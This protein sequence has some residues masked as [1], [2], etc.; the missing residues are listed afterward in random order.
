MTER[1]QPTAVITGATSERGIG[2]TVADRYAGHGVAVVVLDLDG[3]RAAEVAAEIAERPRRA[4]L[5]RGRE[6][7]RRGGGRRSAGRR[8]GRGRSGPPAHGR[9]AREHRQHHLARAV[10]RGRPGPSRIRSWP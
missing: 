2:M 4:R 8:A 6:R 5:R 7:R 3:K 9:R 10:P 1:T